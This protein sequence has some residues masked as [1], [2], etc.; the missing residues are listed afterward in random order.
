MPARL[1]VLSGT[2]NLQ[3]NRAR[4]NQNAVSPLCPLC[5]TED[6]TLEHF[7][8]KCI[9]LQIVRDPVLVNIQQIL[10]VNDVTC[11]KN[12]ADLMKLIIDF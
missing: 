3:V 8:L 6:E 11:V 1:R 10:N 2:H 5:G 4:F 12:A 7:L 9:N